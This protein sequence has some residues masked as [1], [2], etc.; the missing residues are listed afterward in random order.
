MGTLLTKIGKIFSRED[1]RGIRKL[2]EI[3][4]HKFYVLDGIPA[5]SVNRFFYYLSKS[6]EISTLGIP[7]EYFLAIA[8]ELD[9]Y[10]GTPQINLVV[11]QLTGHLRFAVSKEENKWYWLTVATCEAFILI[12]DEPVDEISAAHNALKRDLLIKNPE[13]RFFFTNT[14]ANYLR[15]LENTFSTLSHEEYWKNLRTDPSIEGLNIG[16]SAA[17]T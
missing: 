1:R 5:Y 13:V 14:A 2:T 11:P 16:Q 3:D 17:K 4:G 8:D 10:I 12:D 9:K 7:L 6:E 15:E